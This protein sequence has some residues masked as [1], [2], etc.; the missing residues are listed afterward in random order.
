MKRHPLLV[1]MSGGLDSV[2]ALAVTRKRHPHHEIHVL[3]ASF[4]HRTA[5]QERAAAKRAAKKY[6]AT[7][8]EC[9]LRLPWLAKHPLWDPNCRILGTMDPMHDEFLRS[10]RKK[11]SGKDDRGHLLPY[12]NV[13]LASA[14]AM[15]AAHVGAML[16]YT[17]WD[18][19]PSPGIAED[20]SPAFV[21]DFNQAVRSATKEAMRHEV[22]EITPLFE[23]YKK[24]E[25]LRLASGLGV[26]IART[27]SC[28]NAFSRPCGTCGACWSRIDAHKETGIA[29]PVKYMKR[30]TM[31]R[32]HG[33]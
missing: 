15:L 10:Q 31:R 1:L 8:H 18:Y 32:I 20:K 14:A 3:F 6:N 23:G 30:S 29:D 2:T 28:Y 17:G 16:V 21:A 25:I 26:D 11:R 9:Q 27:W 12:R 24:S 22:P 5:R 19:G 33:L 4:G 7:F 13:L